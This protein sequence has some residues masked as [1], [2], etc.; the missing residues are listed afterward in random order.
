[1]R[2]SGIGLDNFRPAPAPPASKIRVIP[3]IR[4][5]R[6]PRIT[7]THGHQYYSRVNDAVEEP[8]AGNSGA[9]GE[10]KKTEKM[11]KILKE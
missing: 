11:G 9:P 3:I 6:G 7:K 10:L 5:I 4:V 8:A 1:M 2:R